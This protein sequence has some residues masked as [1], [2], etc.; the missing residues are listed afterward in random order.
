MSFFSTFFFLSISILSSY[1]TFLFILSS[2]FVYL[3]RDSTIT[4]LIWTHASQKRAPVDRWLRPIS[5]QIHPIWL[6]SINLI[7]RHLFQSSF[8]II[9]SICESIIK[10]NLRFKAEMMGLTHYPKGTSR[11][12]NVCVNNFIFYETQDISPILPLIGWY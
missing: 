7:S 10:H 2:T 3:V 5:R 1:H 11:T 4:N 9:A 12:N 8:T 6:K